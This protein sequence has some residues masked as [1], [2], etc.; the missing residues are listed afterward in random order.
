MVKKIEYSVPEVSVII[1]TYNRSAMVMRAVQSVLAQTWRNFE[2]IVVDDGS[3]DDTFSVLAEIDD[4]RLRVVSRENGGVSAARNHALNISGGRFI[5][6]LDSDDEWLAEKLEKQLDFMKR[7]GWQISQTEEIWIRNGRRVN[8]CKKHEKPEGFFWERSLEMCMVSPSCVM[9]TRSFLE[10]IGL[11]DE[12]MSACE[13][14][15][16]WIRSGLK[17]PVGLLRESLT[18]KHGGRP[19]QLS[20]SVPCLDLLRIYSMAKML[21]GGDLNVGQR[22]SVLTEIR[23]KAGFYAGG[24]RKRGREHDAL[25][26]EELVE[27][28]VQG[29]SVD[30][31]EFIGN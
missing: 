23:R 20:N 22:E 16:L 19:D 7:G 10:Q 1:P 21:A 29:Y 27:K 25:R 14:Y 30:P 6:L 24:C 9:F 12:R 18:V 15:D 28:L 8:Q 26:I 13:D 4:R 5:A 2:C 17:Y 3:T 31:A 11:F